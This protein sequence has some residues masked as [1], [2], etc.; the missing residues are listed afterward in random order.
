MPQRVLL[1]LTKGT[2]KT[3]CYIIFFILKGHFCPPCPSQQKQG[4][5]LPLLPPQFRHPCL[6][7]INFLILQTVL[8]KVLFLPPDPF[9]LSVIPRSLETFMSQSANWN[10]MIPLI[11]VSSKYAGV[12]CNLPSGYYIP[13]YLAPSKNSVTVHL[14]HYNT[15]LYTLL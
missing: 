11:W 5:Q 12:S 8:P 3:Y 10:M 13:K 9:F 15:F 1:S 6:L 2:L 4:G 7:T 14:H